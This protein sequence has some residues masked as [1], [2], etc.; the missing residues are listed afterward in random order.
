MLPYLPIFIETTDAS[1]SFFMHVQIDFGATGVFI[2]KS[3]VEKYCLNNI[4]AF[5][6]HICLQCQWYP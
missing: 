1:E 4:K 2:N 5:K 3:F 6:V